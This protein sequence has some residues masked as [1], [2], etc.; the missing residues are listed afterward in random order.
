[1][2]QVLLLFRFHP[3][4]IILPVLHT[5]LHVQYVLLTAEGQAAMTGEPFRRR[6]RR[7]KTEEEE[8]NEEYD[9]GKQEK[10]KKKKWKKKKEKKKVKKKKNWSFVNVGALDRKVHIFTKR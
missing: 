10:K 4:D 6:R 9:D 1:M 2:W 7:R 5:L 8:E 3:V